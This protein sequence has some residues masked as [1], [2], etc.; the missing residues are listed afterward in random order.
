MA[1]SSALPTQ[2]TSTNSGSTIEVYRAI[3]DD[4]SSK[5]APEFFQEGLDETCIAMFRQER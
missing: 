5:C 2:L 4:V 3:M 1:A